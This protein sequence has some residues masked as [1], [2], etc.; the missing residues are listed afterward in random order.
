MKRIL[1]LWIVL[2]LLFSFGCIAS[3]SENNMDVLENRYKILQNLDILIGREPGYY[4]GANGEEDIYRDMSKSSFINFLCNISGDHGYTEEYNEDALLCAEG[5]GLIHK[6]QEDLYKPLSFEEAVTMIVRLLGYETHAQQGGG[7]PHGYTLIAKRLGITDG[8]TAKGSDTLKEYEAV[9]LLYNTINTAYVEIAYI[10]EEEGVVYGNASDSTVLYEFRKIYRIEGVVEAT[11]VAALRTGVEVKDGKAVIDSYTY[12]AEKDLNEYLGMQ[13]EA[14]VKANKNG[15]DT[16]LFAI[17]V[18]NREMTIQDVDICDVSA[19]CRTITYL[20]SNGN[21]KRAYL[22]AIA[23]TV[24]NGQALKMPTRD[25]FLMEDGELRL[26]DNDDDSKYDV[27][28]I[29]DYKTI[30]VDYVSLHESVVTNI[31]QKSNPILSLKA[32]DGDRIRLYKNGEEI[33]IDA[34]EHGDVLRVL[35]SVVNGKRIVTAYVAS[36]KFEGTIS[37]VRETSMGQQVTID[38]MEY[39]F[40]SNYTKALKDGDIKA[41][42][43]KLG[44]DYTFYLDTKGKIA[45]VDNVKGANL[46]AIVYAT[47]SDGAF[48]KECKI[49]LFTTEGTWEERV[50]A[51]KVKN[52]ISGDT[53]PESFIDLIP[54]AC[55][56]IAG[57][58]NENGVVSVIEYTLNAEG[59]ISSINLPE[60]FE[61]DGNDGKFNYIAEVNKVY[62]SGNQSMD[63][64][65]FIDS[66]PVYWK[67]Y[68]DDLTDLKSYSASTINIFAT[69]EAYNV[70]AYGVDE[71]GFAKIIIAHKGTEYSAYDMNSAD[72]LMVEDVVTVVDDDGNLVTAITCVN[73]KYAGITYTCED[74]A[75]LAGIRRGD[76]I[77]V[78]VDGAGNITNLTKYRSAAE[79][80]KYENPIDIHVEGVMMHGKIDKLDISNLRVR[81]KV[82]T[83]ETNVRYDRLR[84]GIPV[85]I[86]DSERDKIRVGTLSDLVVGDNVAIKY[87]WDYIW[88]I[89]VYR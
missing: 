83:A 47:A 51:D 4:T 64:T 34:L 67:V 53:N 40:S 13:V 35:E 78:S 80:E 31:Y 48:S 41:R 62:R 27:A 26:I 7:F 86:Y 71:Y 19:D 38:G 56:P 65:I 76:A 68:T 36:E 28:M 15:E 82:G 2:S 5:L 55:A 54:N 88:S 18:R 73:D 25:D 22:S 30:V 57:S 70:S 49:K 20:D 87:K 75:L 17:P 79:L 16:V 59:K 66:D 52:N 8:V 63:S 81:F 50:F 74:K 39:Y 11:E 23:P 45:Y 24:Y 42:M 10:S 60:A 84:T 85:I 32:A 9:N 14:Y 69:N 89:F 58:A 12:N 61:K 77:S 21:E 37:S 6:G 3:A 43:T 1:S 44:T 46:Y 72:L 29:Y 33:Y